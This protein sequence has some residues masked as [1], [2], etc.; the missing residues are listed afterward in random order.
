MPGLKQLASELDLADHVVFAGYQRGP[1]LRA[2]LASCD[3]L[4]TPD[5]PSAYNLSCTMIKTMEYMAMSRPVVGFDMP[6]HR[7]S[8]GDA[9][10]YAK[11]GDELDFARCLRQLMDDPEL[12]SRMGRSGRQRIEDALAWQHQSPL[13]IK[14]YEKLD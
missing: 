1:A 5:P 2:H 14:A 4:T 10:L 9:S 8:A 11:P 13:L 6:E 7:F 12:R 3:I